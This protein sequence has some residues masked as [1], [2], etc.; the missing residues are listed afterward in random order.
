MTRK[1]G[2]GT[3]NQGHHRMGNPDDQ[4]IVGW[5]REY[6]DLTDRIDLLQCQIDEWK[7]YFERNSKLLLDNWERIRLHD[8][9]IVVVEEHRGQHTIE[10]ASMD[11]GKLHQMLADLEKTQADR[12][13]LKRKLCSQQLGSILKD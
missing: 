4:E 5:L 9:I 2:T 12:Q 7:G 13:H 6:R 3:M 10:P 8:S 1:K 11:A